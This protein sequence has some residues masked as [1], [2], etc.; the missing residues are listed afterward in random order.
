MLPG[1]LGIE[2]TQH[3]ARAELASLGID[4]AVDVLDADPLR[5]FDAVHQLN[6][7]RRIVEE[8]HRA[9]QQLAQQLDDLGHAFGTRRREAPAAL[10]Q[11]AVN[12]RQLSAGKFGHR[13]HHATGLFQQA[14]FAALVIAKFFRQFFGCA[15]HGQLFGLQ[16]DASETAFVQRRQVP[17]AMAQRR[18]GIG[19][20]RQDDLGV[21]QVEQTFLAATL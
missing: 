1:A 8:N 7:N 18:L 4:S 17:R 3:T 12:R 10:E 21:A 16:L 2:E 20:G 11:V 9:D 14:Q 6:R 13:P 19:S 15:G 5:S